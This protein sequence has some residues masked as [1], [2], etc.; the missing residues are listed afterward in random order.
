MKSNSIIA[1]SARVFIVVL[2]ALITSVFLLHRVYYNYYFKTIYHVETVELNIM[3]HS[4]PTKISYALNSKNYLELQKTIESN[5]GLFDVAVTDCT[6][7]DKAC[8]G[9]KILFFSSRRTN[10]R[11]EKVAIKAE[12][13]ADGQYDLLKFPP[14]LNTAYAYKH[15][16]AEGGRKYTGLDNNGKTIGRVYYLRTVPPGFLADMKTWLGNLNRMSGRYAS[17]N[18]VVISAL[19][20][21]TLIGLL[22]ELYRKRKQGI[23]QQ[24]EDQNDQVLIKLAKAESDAKTLEKRDKALSAQIDAYK[25]NLAKMN[26]SSVTDENQ[27][28]VSRHIR[29]LTLDL[30]Q[31]RNQLS[32]ARGGRSQLRHEADQISGEL[33]KKAHLSGSATLVAS[34]HE[35]TPCMGEMTFDQ[36][37]HL[38]GLDRILVDCKIQN[39]NYEDRYLNKRGA[40]FFSGFM[41][42]DWV[43]SA[44]NVNFKI[45]ESGSAQPIHKRE[46]A[47]KK[48]LAPLYARTHKI[49]LDVVPS[50]RL[51]L[52][53]RRL[54][55][56]R[57]DGQEFRILFDK[58]MD[59]SELTGEQGFIVREDTYI[60]VKSAATP[61]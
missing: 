33:H 22:F 6:S 14:P 8:V 13:L 50:H 12:A 27:E 43:D 15:A 25:S 10:Q 37:R 21:G 45:W 51:P 40:K 24:L 35:L 34:Y 59:F 29:E 3:S 28:S 41:C 60:V 46:L 52:H 23:L 7:D 11:G 48:N 19:F 39:I 4:F 20:L 31:T 55:I 1:S 18:S 38:I 49:N 32:I 53:A 44:S 9:Q 30:E 5:Y 17:Y 61:A 54:D 2:L 56:Q 36:L 26:H 16:Y 42:G 57:A 47:I 58:G